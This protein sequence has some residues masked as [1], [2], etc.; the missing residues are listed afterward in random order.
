MTDLE[1]EDLDLLL[2]EWAHQQRLSPAEAEQIRRFVVEQPT[3]LPTMWW[4]DFGTQIGAAIAQATNA[5]AAAFGTPTPALV[6]GGS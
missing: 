2:R 4:R 5:S 6:M 3:G 1:P